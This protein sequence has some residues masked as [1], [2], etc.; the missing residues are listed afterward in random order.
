MLHVSASVKT[1][2]Q[3]AVDKLPKAVQELINELYE[4]ANLT[5]KKK[6]DLLVRTLLQTMHTSAQ[7]GVMN[8]ESMVASKTKNPMVIFSWGENRGELTPIQARGYAFQILEASEAAV[9][10]ASLYRGIVETMNM[11]ETKAFAMISLVRDHRRKF[12]S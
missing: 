7:G 2:R 1:G 10:D 12:E 8:V 11:D 9:Q 5:N 3:V 6:L 4:G